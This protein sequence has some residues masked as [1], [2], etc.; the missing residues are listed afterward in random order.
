VVAFPPGPRIHPPDAWGR[1]DGVREAAHATPPRIWTD[2]HPKPRH[3][4]RPSF[5]TERD[6]AQMQRL[7]KPEC[8][9]PIGGTNPE[10]A[11]AA[12]ARRTRRVQTAEAAGRPPELPGNTWPRAIG[13]EAHSVGSARTVAWCGRQVRSVSVMEPARPVAVRVDQPGQACSSCSS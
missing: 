13:H 1:M 12:D 9:P 5:A 11:F 4:P 7:I 8:T 2:S 10:Q 3:E 6:A